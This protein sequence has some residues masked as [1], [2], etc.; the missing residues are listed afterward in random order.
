MKLPEANV[1]RWGGYIFIRENDTG[2]SLEDFLAPLP[3]HFKR[4]KHEECTTAIWVGKVVPANWKVVSEAFM[5]AWHSLVTHPQILPF[6]GDAN[7]S[8]NVWGDNVN[9]ALTL[10]A[11]PSPHLDDDGQATTMDHRRVPEI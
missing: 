4:W 3:E 7:T 10:F 6:T 1:G 8:Y 5:E 2:V 11:V 9:A